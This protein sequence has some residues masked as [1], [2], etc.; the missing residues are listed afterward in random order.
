MHIC[1]IRMC[2]VNIIYTISKIF[3]P[4]SVAISDLR[5]FIW[6]NWISWS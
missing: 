3:S 5:D 4:F 2:Y 6:T 1:D